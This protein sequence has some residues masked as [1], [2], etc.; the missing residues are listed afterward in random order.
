VLLLEF[1]N[2]LI[3]VIVIRG[4]DGMIPVPVPTN[5]PASA[6]ISFIFVAT[7][8]HVLLSKQT[9]SNKMAVIYVIMNERMN[10]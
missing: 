2:N 4:C 7:L 9:L 10:E 8:L 3:E 1:A 5:N 6:A